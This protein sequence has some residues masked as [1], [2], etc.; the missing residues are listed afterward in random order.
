MGRDPMR[1]VENYEVKLRLGA[2]GPVIS[3]GQ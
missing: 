2:N 1:R 3:S